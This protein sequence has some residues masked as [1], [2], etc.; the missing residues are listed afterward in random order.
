MCLTVNKQQS[1]DGGLL[2]TV[3]KSAGDGF[4]KLEALFICDIISESEYLR[5][6]HRLHC[7]QGENG[8]RVS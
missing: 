3:T 7:S 8:G 2:T 4:K 6:L 1:T 5:R